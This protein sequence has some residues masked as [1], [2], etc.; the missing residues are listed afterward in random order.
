MDKITLK[1]M[2]F[3]GYHGLF[4]EE[5]ILG[6]SFAVDVELFLSLEKA[7][8]S[9]DMNDSIDYGQVFNIIKKIVEGKP[10]NLIEAVAEKIANQ[11]LESFSI[12]QS[13]TVKVK[14]INPPIDGQYDFVAIEINRGR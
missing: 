7:G 3:Y 6:Q 8:R 5:K 9:D 10:K 12:L 4:P 1:N 11:L 13:C 14:K 2:K